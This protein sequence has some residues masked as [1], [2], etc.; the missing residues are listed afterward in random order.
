M[1]RILF[2]APEAF[3]IKTSE[4][5]C[6]SKVAFALAQ[7]GYKVDVFTCS[8]IT[9]YPLDNEIEAFLRNS[10]NLNV[11][12][13]KSKYILSKQFSL[14][15][16]IKN[17]LK[18]LYVF[19]KTGLWYNG[20]SIPYGIVCAVEKHIKESGNISYDVIITRGFS[21]DYAGIY[22]KKKYGIKWIANWNDPFPVKR[23]PAPYGKGFDARLPYFEQ[24]IYNLIQ[25]YADLHTFPSDRL[26][27]Y[28]LK[29]FTR[30]SESQTLVIPHMAHSQLSSIVKGCKNEDGVFKI[31]HCGS[32]GK[33]RNPE[34]FIKALSKM[35]RK[36]NLTRKNIRCYFVGNYDEN[37]D[38]FVKENNI[39]T[40]VELLP[41]KGYT[42]S[43]SFI[44]SCNMTLIIEAVCEEGIYLPTK[45][46]DSIQCGLPPFCI[47]PNPGTL[48][49]MVNKYGIGYSALNTSV[50]DIADKLETAYYDFQEG[51]VNPATPENLGYFFEENIVSLFTSI[52][53]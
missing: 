50:S 43:L 42:E 44:S 46:V 26:R 36:N 15:Q 6:N 16:N 38:A 25:K 51:K 12:G 48:N 47:S 24:R 3:P 28:M 2:I 34:N 31:V 35:I 30:I 9:T 32:V 29:C 22:L 49:D 5:I 7:A 4:S 14:K 20:I 1:K 8:D 40:V 53:D 18:N 27:K 21:T 11:Y 52:I 10:S 39:E 37:L 41:P 33:P 19:L 23:F 13:V 17:L 45:F